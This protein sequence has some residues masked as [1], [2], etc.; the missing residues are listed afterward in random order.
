MLMLDPKVTV[1]RISIKRG[2]SPKKQPHRCF[3]LKLV[4]EIEKEINKLIKA[5][6]IR[7]VK[8]PTWIAN[9]IPVRKKNGQLRICVDFR[10]LNDACPKD[11]FP[12][13]VMKIMID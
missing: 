10:D 2:I 8:Y 5:G 12:L 4:L 11:D 3:C 13:P 1:H 6:F 7:E 9:I